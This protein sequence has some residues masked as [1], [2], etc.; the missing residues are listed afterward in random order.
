MKG[1]SRHCG[2]S[3]KGEKLWDDN[4]TLEQVLATPCRYDKRIEK[5][6]E[7]REF[8]SI[9]QVEAEL[10]FRE[11]EDTTARAK[12]NHYSSDQWFKEVESRSLQR[13]EMHERRLS[14]LLQEPEMT[15][16]RL[17]DIK[18]EDWYRLDDDQK[19]KLI[20]DT[21]QDVRWWI[22]AETR[23]LQLARD[24]ATPSIV[25]AMRVQ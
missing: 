15:T 24:H 25:M 21:T 23:E 10:C 8:P 7:T 2:Y 18:W 19:A 20:E 3:A 4:R 17:Q 13:K 22:E 14:D 11:A 9:Q 1:D 16:R 12:R 5:I 6:K